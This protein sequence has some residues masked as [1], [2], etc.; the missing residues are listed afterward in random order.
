MKAFNKRATQKLFDYNLLS[1]EQY[2]EISNY[3]KL[4]LF[5]LNGELKLFLYF[6]VL[7]FTSGMGILIYENINTL[8]HSILIGLLFI[9]TLICY[10]I[11]FK[12]YKGFHKEETPFDNPLYDYLVLTA[13]I[14]SCLF[15]AYLQFQYTTFGTHYGL[16]T[17]VPT[18]LGLFTSYYFDNKNVLSIA[19]TGLTAYIGLTVSPQ[20]LLQNNFYDSDTLSYSA[21]GLGVVF[22]VWVVYSN[23]INLK[24]H[25][26]LVY[27][28][29]ALHLISISCL[30]NLYKPH[31]ILFASILAASSFYFYKASYQ[32]KSVSLFVFTVLYAFF[33]LNFIAYKIIESLQFLELYIVLAYLTPFYFGGTIYLFIQ[34]IKKFN[35]EIK[36]DR[37]Q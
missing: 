36:D 13:S 10:Y 23:R 19:L 27:L 17:L 3:R 9:V 26:A 1:E 7:L 12:K 4:N 5:S 33:G 28:T 8:G 11:C 31:W 14:L 2:S 37:T 24:K 21:I 6:S 20:T 30:T 22:I 35:S 15:I 25:F 18:A 16:A 29:F 32:L 34:L